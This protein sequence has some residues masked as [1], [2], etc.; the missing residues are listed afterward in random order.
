MNTNPKNFKYEYVML[1][2]DIELDNF[3]NKNLITTYGFSEKVYVANSANG[4]L[5]F[6]D[7]LSIAACQFPQICPGVIFVDINMPIMDGFQFIETFKKT[8]AK[9]P[10]KPKLVVLT[11]SAAAMDRE[12]T[13]EISEEIFFMNKP[14]TKEMLDTI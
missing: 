5:E 12:K 14:L 3:I 11:S 8:L 9:Q 2:D 7:N 13:F 4:A 1:I 6:L 10:G